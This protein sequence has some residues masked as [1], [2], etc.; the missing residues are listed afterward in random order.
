MYHAH[1]HSQISVPNGMFGTFLVGDNP[2]PATARRS[3]AITIPDDVDP[4]W[5]SRWCSTT[6]A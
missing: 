4:P 5:R 3:P 1:I 6:P 2:H